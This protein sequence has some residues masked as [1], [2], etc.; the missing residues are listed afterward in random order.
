MD[1]LEACLGVRGTAVG[2]P[3]QRIRR[4]GHIVAGGGLTPQAVRVVKGQLRREPLHAGE[5]LAPA[6]VAC[7]ETIQADRALVRSFFANPEG[8]YV[9]KALKW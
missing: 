6:V 1:A 5:H 3:L 7:R 8:A 9:K 2:S 4:G